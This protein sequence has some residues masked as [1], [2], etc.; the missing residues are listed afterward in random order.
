MSPPVEGIDF[1]FNGL[2][3]TDFLLVSTSSWLGTP[4]ANLRFDVVAADGPP[5]TDLA[6]LLEAAAYPWERK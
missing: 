5:T 3:S 2:T 1:D 6:A 4:P